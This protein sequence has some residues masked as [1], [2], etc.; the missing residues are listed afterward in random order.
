RA[1][2]KSKTIE[3]LVTACEYDR[4]HQSSTLHN[5]LTFYSFV[6]GRSRLDWKQTYQCIF[7]SILS[8][9]LPKSSIAAVLVMH[10]SYVFI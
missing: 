8:S 2:L 10:A 7:G 6:L 4:S 1:R 5:Q 9:S 3:L